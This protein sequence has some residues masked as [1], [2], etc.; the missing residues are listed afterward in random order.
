VAEDHRV[1][2]T[3]PSGERR[4]EDEGD[5]RRKIAEE[6]DEPENV[7][8]GVELGREVVDDKAVYDEPPAKAST[9]KSAERE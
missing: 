3:E 9:E 7:D 1:I 2:E 5:P 6:E 4:S 8:P